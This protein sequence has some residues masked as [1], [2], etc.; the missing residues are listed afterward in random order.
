MEK[1]KENGMETG[2]SIGFVELN[3]S[4]YTGETLSFTIYTH[5][6]HFS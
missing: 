6:G 4:Y 5:C 1:N 2:G 3:L